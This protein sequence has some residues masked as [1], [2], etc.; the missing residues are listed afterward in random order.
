MQT[1]SRGI[2]HY[3][4]TIGPWRGPASPSAIH[5]ALHW[6][7]YWTRRERKD[8]ITCVIL[9]VNP[10]SSIRPIWFFPQFLMLLLAHWT[11]DPIA[12]LSVQWYVDGNLHKNAYL[13]VFHGSFHF[14]YWTNSTCLI[15]AFEPSAWFA[16]CI[17]YNGP[18]IYLQRNKIN[19]I[20][21]CENKINYSHAREYMWN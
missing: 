21:D 6:H 19:G 2:S 3:S 20:T 17:Y 10:S 1:R 5:L 12:P 4:I 7:Q 8:C 18:R 11:D 13:L 9:I 15:S 16:T 14:D